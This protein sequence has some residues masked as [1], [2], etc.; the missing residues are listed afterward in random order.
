LELEPTIDSKIK[1]GKCVCDSDK[2]YGKNPYYSFCSHC[3]DDLNGTSKNNNCVCPNGQGILINE[4]RGVGDRIYKNKCDKCPPNYKLTNSTCLPCK[5][6]EV[7]INGGQCS[8]CP[9]GLAKLVS[10]E[11]G[12]CPDSSFVIKDNMCVCPDGYGIKD[13][14]CV[15]CLANEVKYNNDTCGTCQ[16]GYGVLNG[17]CVMCKDKEGVRSDGTC[18]ACPTGQGI[19]QDG[20][21]SVCTKGNDRM[22]GT[23]RTTDGKCD[24]QKIVNR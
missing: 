24:R 10:G 3:K 20:K 9:K 12:K 2:G 6:N 13:K 17:K 14:K 19:L 22:T 8:M 4:V 15:A 21:C 18:G 5:S 11:C 23:I 1:D 7:A 16:N